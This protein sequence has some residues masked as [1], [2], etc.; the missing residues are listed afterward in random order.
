MIILIHVIIALASIAAT[1]LTALFPSNAR[2]KVSGGLVAATFITG[3]YLVVRLHVPLV[4]TCETGLVY[5]MVT[6][7]GMAIGVRRLALAKQ[8]T[9]R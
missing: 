4:Q 1:S 2:L 7:A 3:T 6:T 9:Q 5:L 8:R